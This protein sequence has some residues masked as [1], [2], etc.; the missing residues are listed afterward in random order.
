MAT[1]RSVTSAW[2]DRLVKQRL[3]KALD[4]ACD[5]LAAKVASNAPVL[6]G[7]MRD[8]VHATKARLKKT[9][10]VAA[11]VVS[12][13]HALAEEYGNAHQAAHPFFRPAILSERSKMIAIVRS[14]TV[15]R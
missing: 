9:R 10:I 14:E 12:S 6:T 5:L 15:T 2:R 11:V 7:E 4:R 1:I 8:A 13:D 3:P